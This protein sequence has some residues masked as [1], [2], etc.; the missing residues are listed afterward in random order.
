[1]DFANIEVSKFPDTWGASPATVTVRDELL[2]I[3]AGTYKSK[4]EKARSLHKAGDSASYD[5]IKKT[6]PAVTWSG[7]FSARLD[8]SLIHYSQLLIMDLDHLDDVALPKTKS[9]LREDEYVVSVWLSPSGSGL[10]FLVRTAVTQ[11][12]HKP[13]YYAFVD[14]LKSRYGINVDVSGSN[15][16]RLCYAS[17]DPELEFKE[18]SRI[19]ELSLE[20]FEVAT[21]Y[22][23]AKAATL[24]S[25]SQ[26]KNERYLLEGTEGRN[27]QSLHRII[28]RIITYLRNSNQSITS[29]YAEWVKVGLAI[30]NTFTFSGIGE[31]YFLELSAQDGARYD[32]E[33]CK[34]MLNYL[35][36][37]RR[38]NA[39]TMG[40]IIR[41]AESKG[42]P[43]AGAKHRK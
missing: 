13:V 19:F 36:L 12:L 41:M 10:K 9:L 8:S 30:A 33:A 5:S 27:K 3:Q 38:I 28:R 6:L 35:Y 26:P 24:S 14:Y 17:Y 25:A 15:V 20:Q 37:H 2:S 29:S 32:A 43:K 42:F 22:R 4:I 18:N 40:S 16:G 11:E 1:M 34:Q 21:T 39:V 23:P 31:R 7:L